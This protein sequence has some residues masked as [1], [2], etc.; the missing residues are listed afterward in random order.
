MKRISVVLMALV[1]MVAMCGV[2]QAGTVT[3]KVGVNG[4]HFG[5]ASKSVPTNTKVVWKGISGSHTVTAY[6][7]NWS[8]S[9]SVSAGSS[10]AFTF[11]KPGVYKYRCTFHSS[12]SG[13]TCSGMC[14]KIVVS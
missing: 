10:T 7:K 9:A 2:A 1:L 6:S 8:K 12:L 5:P 11:K 14:G 4:N 13:S 3:V